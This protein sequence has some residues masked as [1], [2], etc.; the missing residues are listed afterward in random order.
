LIGGLEALILRIQLSQPDNNFFNSGRVQCNV[1]NAWD[2][3]DF[4][5]NYAN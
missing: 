1:Y 4:L 5:G 2:H 3:N